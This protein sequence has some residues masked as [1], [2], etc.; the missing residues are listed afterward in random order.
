M[1][2]WQRKGQCVCPATLDAGHR[3]LPTHQINGRWIQPIAPN[4]QRTCRKDQMG[5]A[6]Q[7]LGS[8]TP[9]VI[10]FVP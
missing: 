4:S 3:G 8:V 10:E 9:E 2:W 7:L 5:A 6:L 1:G